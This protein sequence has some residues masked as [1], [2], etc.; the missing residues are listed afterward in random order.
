MK[1]EPLVVGLKKDQPDALTF[2]VEWALAHHV[3]VRVVH[4]VD[5]VSDWSDPSLS[6]L[7]WLGS[8]QDILESAQRFI[9]GI[10]RELAVDYVLAP[11]PV[12]EY[13]GAEARKAS[14]IV[15][16]HDEQRWLDRL[17]EGHTAEELA[18]HVDVP[19][20]IVPEG[21]LPAESSRIVVAIDGR[22]AAVGPLRFAF[23]EASRRCKPLHIVHAAPVGTMFTKS[24][25]LR[26]GMAEVL[27]GWSELYPDVAV[28]RHLVFDESDEGWRLLSEG[29]GLLVVGRSQAGAL[30]ILDRHP[31]LVHLARTTRCP[32]VVVSDTWDPTDLRARTPFAHL[33]LSA[34]S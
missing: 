9:A 28:Q 7:R 33:D 31:V 21:G 29:A 15:V 13:L 27:A 10:D 26:A 2:A 16:G 34:I 3:G 19:L 32:T 1:G 25:S 24:V 18:T 14:M 20:A 8:E 6:D 11:G 23:D 5:P 30:P 4:C 22:T 12:E 17:F